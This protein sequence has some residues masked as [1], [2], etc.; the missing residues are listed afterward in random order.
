MTS[1]GP[2]P[3]EAVKLSELFTLTDSLWNRLPLTH[4]LIRAQ[5]ILAPKSVI[6]TYN[7]P[8]DQNKPDEFSMEEANIFLGE[9][10]FKEEKVV[11]TPA[12]PETDDETETSPPTRPKRPIKSRS[13]FATLLG[14]KQNRI[15]VVVLVVG[16]SFALYTAKRRGRPHRLMLDNLGI[17]VAEELDGVQNWMG[18]WRSSPVLRESIKRVDKI[19]AKLPAFADW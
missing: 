3:L 14:N 12:L 18:K 17:R 1:D 9:E 19:L 8:G 10:G 7:E 6:F 15:A 2:N 11:I 16:I 13:P 4:D 5:E